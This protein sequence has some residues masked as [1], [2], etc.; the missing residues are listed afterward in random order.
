MGK[1]LIMQHKGKGKIGAQEVDVVVG[2]LPGAV[3]ITI[4]GQN[5]LAIGPAGVSLVQTTAE[6]T[7]YERDAQRRV[8]IVPWQEN[9]ARMIELHRKGH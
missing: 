7:P 5:V 8:N 1:G 6:E 3:T 9:A 2:E 4:N